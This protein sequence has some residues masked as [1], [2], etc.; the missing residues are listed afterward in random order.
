MSHSSSTG[1]NPEKKA[2]QR[3]R[4][5]DPTPRL[6]GPE[7]TLPDPA[8]QPPANFLRN[9]LGLL[10][11]AG[12]VGGIK[13]AK[14]SL[15][16]NTG[17]NSA[18]PIVVEDDDTPT[19]GRLSKFQH[20]YTPPV[21]P[22]LLPT[23]PIQ[24]VVSTLIVQKDIFPVLENLLRLIASCSSDSSLQTSSPGAADTQRRP[25]S[26]A[27]LSPRPIKK[28]KLNRVPAGAVDWDV[29]YPFPPG[30][31]PN[32]YRTTWE[33]QRGKQLLSQLLGLIKGAA[34]KAATKIYYQNANA[35]NAM[36]EAQRVALQEKP[37]ADHNEAKVHGHY[38]PVTTSYGLKKQVAPA[39]LSM[40]EAP[41]VA[42]REN[43]GSA[44]GSFRQTALYHAVSGTGG[45]QLSTPFDQLISS[46]LAASP[47]KSATVTQDV[48]FSFGNPCNTNRPSGENFVDQGL[49]DSWMDILQTFPIPSA[50]FGPSTE[51]DFRQISTSASAT[52]S[53]DFGLIDFDF[54]PQ[55]Q[56]GISGADTPLD[57][58]AVS[59]RLIDP[60]VLAMSVSQPTSPNVV[61]SPSVPLAPSPVSS[62]ETPGPATPNSAIWD[63]SMPDVYTGSNSDGG[64]KG[65]QRRN[66]DGQD[67][68]ALLGCA[69]VQKQ[70]KGKDR[71]PQDLGAL[72]N[73]SI[74]EPIAQPTLNSDHAHENI[75][76]SATT[77]QAT[78]STT[79]KQP[80]RSLNKEEILRRANERRAQLKAELD[81]VRTQLWETTIEQGVLVHLVKHY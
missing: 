64:F 13:P 41:I 8:D 19:L 18:N 59:D 14:L 81:R 78:P 5:K 28:R 62:A 74:Q 16:H 49:Y 2:S 37:K 43:K 52:T 35:Q 75:R 29:P 36:L 31:G 77:S 17:T 42:S 4:L 47:E 72:P 32:A 10:G 9:Q 25:V 66:L 30:E 53:G 24:D 6:P 33:R 73:P 80:E 61:I 76:V 7:I 55:S 34:R 45:E 27:T 39:G 20:P 79:S 15:R 22:S 54:G 40:V 38:R 48:G 1:P 50:G 57:D 70:D 68:H 26:S 60:A 46:L 3:R 21:D 63:M 11:T 71:E 67:C 44:M 51:L 23:P 65:H 69:N 56:V 58:S 12:L